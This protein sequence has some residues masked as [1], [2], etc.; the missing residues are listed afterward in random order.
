ML[1]ELVLEH[2][3]LRW[4]IQLSPVQMAAVRDVNMGF[5]GF[6]DYCATASV[7]LLVFVCRLPQLQLLDWGCQPTFSEVGGTPDA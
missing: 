2:D 7:M 4:L 5:W 6:E 3:D 1:P